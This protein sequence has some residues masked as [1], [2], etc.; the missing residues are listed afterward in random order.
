L[1]LSFVPTWEVLANTFTTIGKTIGIGF[2]V[3]KG[4]IKQ[5]FAFF[6][7]KFVGRKLFNFLPLLT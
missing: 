3:G 2:A 7:I 5:F 6:N 4:C 1:P